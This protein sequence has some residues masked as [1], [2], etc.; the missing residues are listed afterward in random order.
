MNTTKLTPDRAALLITRAILAAFII[1]VV[2]IVVFANVDK[3][4]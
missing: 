4:A 3:L 1:G 2:L